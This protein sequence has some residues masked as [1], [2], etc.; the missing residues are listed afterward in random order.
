MRTL[1][2]QPWLKPIHMFNINDRMLE[3][4]S[5]RMVVV[6]NTLTSHYE[7]HSEDSY[8]GNL[9]S[10]NGMI[11]IE[12]LNG[13]LIKDLK[14]TNLRANLDYF[15]DVRA[16][17]EFMWDMHEDNLLKNN[18]SSKLKAVERAIGRRL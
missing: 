18:V 5:Q 1:R 8:E 11:N 9:M 14:A 7:I 15:R 12:Y 16:E 6:F 2:H 3:E 10:S 13:Y 4:T 17:K